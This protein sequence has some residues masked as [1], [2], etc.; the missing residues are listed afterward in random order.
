MANINPFN[1]P[2]ML[3]FDELENMLLRIS[4]GSE[5]FPPYNIEQLAHDKMRIS[6]AVAGYTEADLDVSVEENQLVIRG[7]QAQD[8]TRRFLHH[9][10][11]G[12]SFIKSFV[13]ADGLKITEAF[14]ENGLLNIDLVK[15]EKPKNIRQI[16]IRTK[17]TSSNLLTTQENN[18]E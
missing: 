5:S 14:L 3:G 8:E 6:L 4:K 10:I 2:F 11:A 16:A 13:L 18:H 7:H 12:R 15:P 1:N 9:G 17:K